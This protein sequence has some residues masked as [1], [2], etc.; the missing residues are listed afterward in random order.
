MTVNDYFHSLHSLTNPALLI[1]TCNEENNKEI[2][3][4]DI[5]VKTGN[6]AGNPFFEQI[7]TLGLMLNVDLFKSISSQDLLRWCFY[8]T[9]LNLFRALKFKWRM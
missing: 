4:V 6:N 2:A 1:R 8:L 9:I 7:N 5:D 3:N